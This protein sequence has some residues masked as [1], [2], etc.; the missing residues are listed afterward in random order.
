MIVC[1][2]VVPVCD[3][4]DIYRKRSRAFI[5]TSSLRQS[6]Y[7]TLTAGDAKQK[8]DR[9]TA[10]VWIEVTWNYSNCCYRNGLITYCRVCPGIVSGSITS[11]IPPAVLTQLSTFFAS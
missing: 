3:S 5:V 1:D 7:N 8:N 2:R 9:P 6:H 11:S 10:E 4:Y